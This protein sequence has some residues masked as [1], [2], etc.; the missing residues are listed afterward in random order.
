MPHRFAVIFP[1]HGVNLSSYLHRHFTEVLCNLLWFLTVNFIHFT[2]ASIA[3]VQH[4]SNSVLYSNS[5]FKYL[6]YL[7]PNIW[8]AKSLINSMKFIFFCVHFLEMFRVF[9]FFKRLFTELCI[10]GLGKQVSF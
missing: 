9:A 5:I 1:C 4:D 8:N 7:K 6:S 10:Y 2:N 3:S